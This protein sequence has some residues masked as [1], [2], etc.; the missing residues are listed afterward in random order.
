MVGR[1]VTERKRNE[2]MLTT[3]L[4]EKAALLDNALVGIV[5]VREHMIVSC[6]RRFE[7]MLGYAAGKL[8]G[9]STRTLFESDEPFHDFDLEAARAF[10][11]GQQFSAKTLLVKAGRRHPLRTDRTPPPASTIGEG[12]HLDD[13]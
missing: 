11:N 5:N 3:L 8:I 2:E 12:Q 4:T 13:Q 10:E 7:E 9:R 6:N 1:D